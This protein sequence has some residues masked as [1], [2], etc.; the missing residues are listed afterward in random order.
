[1]QSVTD[2]PSMVL[3]VLYVQHVGLLGG[4]SRSLYEMLSGFPAGAVA[5]HVVVPQG[6]LAE[7]LGDRGIPVET[8]RGIAQFDNCAY[9]YYRGMRWIILLRE[10]LLLLPTYHALMQARRRWDRFDVVH[11]NDITMPFVAW[12]ARRL[13]RDSVIVVHARAV[14]RVAETCR[15]RWLQRLYGKCADAVVAINENVRE[16]LPEG[17]PVRVIHNGMAVPTGASEG[18]RLGDAGRLFSAAMVGM[19]ARAKGCTDFVEAAAICR[20]RG[21]RIRFLLIGERLGAAKGWR[22]SLLQWLGFKE[23]IGVE[24]EALIE[25]LRLEG[26]VVFRPFT[27]DLASIYN[28]MDV[29]CFPSYLDAP[30]RPIF[31]A[32]FFGVPSIAAISQPRADTFVDGK[33]GL[34]VQAGAPAELADAIIRL[35]DDAEARVCM[36]AAARSM[37]NERFDAAKNAQKVLS[38]YLSLCSGR[39][40]KGH[41]D[42]AVV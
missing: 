5:P 23:D 13:F 12:A 16:S 4:S 28:D 31:E 21:Y 20:D 3:R 40:V 38:L 11:V 2:A 10:F 36:G 33:T 1:M 42:G 26:L 32:G 24:I 39:A 15:K 14:Q 22:D 35:H 7:M 37:A 41:G 25:H 19:L 9:S 34:L 18:R 30:G 8:C 17:L 6:K 27:P 29:L